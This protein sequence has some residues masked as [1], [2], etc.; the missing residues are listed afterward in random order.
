M[1]DEIHIDDFCRDAALIL[2]YLYRHFPRKA[3]LYVEDIIGP[4]EQDEYGLHSV[5]HL[6]CLSTM[7][8]LAEEGFIRYEDTIR[9]EALDQ[10]VIAHAP[11]LHLTSIHNNNSRFETMDSEEIA[12]IP[13]SVKAVKYSNI[14]QIHRAL[15]SGSSHNVRMIMLDFFR[16][17][18]SSEKQ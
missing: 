14:A 3:T 7:I 1:I 5:R 18:D 16:Q 2:L 6:S 12:N 13:E 17:T 4:E 15:Q 11:F 10:V 9:Q 8:W